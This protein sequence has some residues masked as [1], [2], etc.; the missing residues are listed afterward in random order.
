MVMH[1]LKTIY[2]NNR[3]MLMKLEIVVLSVFCLIAQSCK[4]NTTEVNNEVGTWTKVE[5]GVTNLLYD[6][7]F[8]DE[9]NGWVVGDS[10]IILHSSNGGESWQRQTCPIKDILFAVDFVDNKNGWI[11]SRNSILMTTNGGESW[12]VKHSQE[13][14]E[15]RFRDIQFLNKDIGF[16]VGGMGSFGSIGVLLKTEDG[17]ETWQQVSLNRLPTL[18]HISIVDEQ[19]IWVCGFGGTILSTRDIGLTWTKKNINI[20]PSPS[21]TTIQFVDKFYGWVGSRDDYLGFFRTTDGGSTWIQRSRDSWPVFLGVLT[22]FFIDTLNGW[23]A[24]FPGAGPYAIFHTTD[25]GLKWEYLPEDTNVYNITSFC[26]INKDLGWAVGMEVL[27][28]NAVGV[29]LRYRNIK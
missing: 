8:A 15:G 18:T 22:F 5:S 17:G 24:T 14:G 11:C 25:G 29:I 3:V 12:E 13:L 2:V 27:N 1:M 16:V 6:I 20:S 9:Q 7:D 4:D 23:L 26:F 10:G 21:L 28:T 19:N